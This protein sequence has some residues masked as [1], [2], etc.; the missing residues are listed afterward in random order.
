MRSHPPLFMRQTHLPTSEA[1]P[2]L[3]VYIPL[4]TLS[5]RFRNFSL[6]SFSSSFLCSQ[7]MFSVDFVMGFPQ[8]V[9]LHFVQSPPPPSAFP[10]VQHVCDLDILLGRRVGGGFSDARGF[11][12]IMWISRFCL[13]RKFA[14]MEFWTFWRTMRNG[15]PPANLWKNS[16]ISGPFEFYRPIPIP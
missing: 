14:T 11:S 5:S 12:V 3:P 13:P 15:I 4:Y 10:L 9:V 8:Y 1:N 6:F 7:S 16:L 2:T